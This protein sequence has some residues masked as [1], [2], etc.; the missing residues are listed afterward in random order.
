MDEITLHLIALLANAISGAVAIALRIWWWVW[1][2]FV[3]VLSSL[4]FYIV[5]SLK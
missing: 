2:C 4:T 1:L 5:D 3:G